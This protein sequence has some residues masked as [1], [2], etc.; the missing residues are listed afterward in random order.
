MIKYLPFLIGHWVICVCVV[1]GSTLAWCNDADTD[2]DQT[3][4]FFVGEPLEMMT[5]ASKRL[6]TSLN[7]PAVAR[8]IS[9]GEIEKRGVQTL[10]ELL[11]TEPGFYMNHRPSGTVPYLRG[12]QDGVLFLYDGVPMTT[13]ATRNANALDHETPLSNVQRVEIIRGPGSVLWGADAFAGIV[14]VVPF[15]GRHFKGVEF[16]SRVGTDHYRAGT[17][18][19]GRKTAESESFMSV[20]Y[21]TDRYHKT[22]YRAVSSIA[23]PGSY[24]MN[25]IDDSSY[26]EVIGNTDL[27]KKVRLSGR[28]S[29]THR[30]YVLNDS[31]TLS[32]LGEKES[33][34]GFV[35]GVYEDR[36]GGVDLTATGYVQYIEYNTTNVDVE[37]RQSDWIYAGELLFHKSL[38]ALNQVT[39]G[40]SFRQNHVEGAP[41]KNDFLP[42]SLKPENSVFVPDVDQVDYTNTLL[43]VFAQYRHKWGNQT[44]AFAGARYDNHSEYENTVSYNMGLNHRFP[45]NAQIKLMY[46]TAFRT[47]FPNQLIGIDPLEPERNDTVNLQ[48][49]WKQIRNSQWAVTLF[50]SQIANY[51]FEDPYGGLSFPSELE[52]RGVELSGELALTPYLDLYANV[53]AMS[54]HADLLRYRIPAYTFLQPDGTKITVYDEWSQPYD[55]GP[56]YLFTLGGGWR[57]LPNTLLTA[58]LSWNSQV[59]F[60]FEK[61]E[62]NGDFSVTPTV[63]LG[64]KWRNIMGTGLTAALNADNLFDV[65]NRTI[66]MYGPSEDRPFQV[67]LGLSYQY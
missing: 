13:N 31:S 23:A 8:V 63:S 30:K 34:S 62:I 20:Y 61:N 43:S 60:S 39:L 17:V 38:S 53:T 25:S 21:A 10:S 6:E 67:Y 18:K 59:P 42:G 58:R 15:K 55:A 12:V 51:A 44:D 48:V 64:V 19:A 16:E 40:S 36:F 22:D 4:L 32:W 24:G 26:L 28:L 14:N 45:Q 7:A 50:Y 27:G 46:G 9:A 35:K 54:T 5:L 11:E 37:I 33:P 66:G 49:L 2:M 1:F 41:G 57:F 65:R 52:I 3:M 56:Q 29:N 47:P